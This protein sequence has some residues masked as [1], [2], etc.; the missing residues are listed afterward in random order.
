[1]PGHPLP[2]TTKECRQ[3][4]E[5]ILELAESNSLANEETAMKAIERLGKKRCRLAIIYII[6]EFSRNEW[7]MKPRLVK[8]A[9]DYL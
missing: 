1:M 4:L 7:G 3:L 9:K 8:K 6:R 2:D 5:M